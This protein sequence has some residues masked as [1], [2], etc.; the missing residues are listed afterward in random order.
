MI[1]I[2]EKYKMVLKVQ[3]QPFYLFIY[4]DFYN[5]KKRTKKT[6]AIKVAA[7]SLILFV[8]VKEQVL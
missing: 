4:F 1:V 6:C 8:S 7:S 2:H 3:G 5:L